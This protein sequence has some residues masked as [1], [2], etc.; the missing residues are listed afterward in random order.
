MKKIFF[1]VN[2]LD[3]FDFQDLIKKY[4]PDIRVSAGE[5]LP[6]H[7]ED[8]DLVILWSYKKII[9]NL[10]GKKNIILFHS[11]DLPKGKGWAPIYYTIIQKNEYFTITGILADEKVDAGNVI[12]KARFK[13]KDNYTAEHLR[14]WDKEISIM[15][16]KEILARFEG[17]KLEGIR[18]TGKDSF[19]KKRS[20]EDN[21]ISPDVKVADIIDHLRACERSHSAYFIYNDIKYFIYIEPAEKPDFPDDLEVKFYD[22]AQ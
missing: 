20:P 18:Q 4:L 3:E 19:Y 8:Y 1:L 15:L 16:I 10:S 2:S 22:S 6:E 17:K 21:E 13:I 11:T 9:P 12:V 14:G 5:S 7:T